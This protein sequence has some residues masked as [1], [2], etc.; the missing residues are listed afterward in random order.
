MTPRDER[1]QQKEIHEHTVGHHQKRWP[2]PEWFGKREPISVW[3][4]AGIGQNLGKRII[5]R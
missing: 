2:V 1:V 4:R 3:T 5:I